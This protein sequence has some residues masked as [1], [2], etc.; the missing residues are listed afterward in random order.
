MMMFGLIMQFSI[1]KEIREKFT[2][3][4][5]L[6]AVSKSDLMK[7]SPVVYATDEPCPAQLDMEKYRK[8]GPDGAINVSVKT[9]EGLDEVRK[10]CSKFSYFRR[11]LTFWACVE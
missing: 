11:S 10:I 1:Y 9:Q 7:A 4:L 8:S 3:H 6:D 2:G 5:W